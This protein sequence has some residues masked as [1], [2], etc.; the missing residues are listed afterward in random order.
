VQVQP[1]EVATPVVLCCFEQAKH[2]PFY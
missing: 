2:I 1:A